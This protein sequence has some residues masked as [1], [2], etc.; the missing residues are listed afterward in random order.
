M[1]NLKNMSCG[2]T[3]Q[4]GGKCVKFCQVVPVLGDE[5]TCYRFDWE[6]MHIGNLFGVLWVARSLERI[7]PPQ[8]NDAEIMRMWQVSSIR[9]LGQGSALPDPKDAQGAQGR[10]CFFQQFPASGSNVILTWLKRTTR[11]LPGAISQPDNKP[12]FFMLGHDIHTGNG[13]MRGWRVEQSEPDP[14]RSPGPDGFLEQVRILA[15]KLF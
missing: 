4:S 8:A 5:A 14:S 1:N 13:V 3:I 15:G 10:P 6:S 11:D 7:Y 2:R 9:K 12:T